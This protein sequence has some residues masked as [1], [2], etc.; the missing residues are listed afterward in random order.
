MSGKEG[1]QPSND[2]EKERKRRTGNEPSIQKKASQVIF[3]SQMVGKRDQLG[4]GVQNEG[5]G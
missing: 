1:D 3:T 5:E 2:V 4:R